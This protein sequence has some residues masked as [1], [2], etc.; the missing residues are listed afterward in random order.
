MS[1]VIQSTKVSKK[2]KKNRLRQNYKSE[3]IDS[4]INIKPHIRVGWQFP[5]LGRKR[6]MFAEG[7]TA[8]WL[9]FLSWVVGTRVFI[10]PLNRRYVLDPFE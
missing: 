5:L 1:A 9:S 6:D 4:G 10:I 8:N 7:Y 2:R 3:D